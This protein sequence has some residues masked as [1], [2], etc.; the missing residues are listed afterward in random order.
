MSNPSLNFSLKQQQ[1]QK[2]ALTQQMQQSI[3]I[4]Q[5][6]QDELSTYITD[7]ASENPLFEV[8]SSI[9]PVQQGSTTK[10]LNSR[11]YPTEQMSI[12]DQYTSLFE[13][14]IDQVHLNYRD[15]P[16]RKAILFLVEFIDE[17]GYL[18]LSLDDAMS[19][20]SADYLLVLDALTLLQQLDPAGIGA[21]NLQECLMLQTERN[22]EAPEL[23]YVV[24]EEHFQDLADRKWQKISDTYD[25]PVTD[26]Q[27]IMDYVQTL[28]PAPGSH[29]GTID[30][31]YIV[32]EVEV[33]V[34]D[35]QL[36]LN[37]LQS[38]MPKMKFQA[39]Y[40]DKMKATGDPE[41]I[42][43]LNEKKR[44]FDWLSKTVDQRRNTI[45]A[46]TEAIISVQHDFFL[47]E[48][49]PLKSLT[50]KQVGKM[51]GI[52]ES[53]VSRAVNG[54]YLKTDFGVYELRTFFVS[55]I[56]GQSTS[57]PEI[58]KQIIELISAEDKR[59]PISDQKMSDLL[60]KIGISIS[61]RT[62]AKYRENLGIPATSKRKR[63]DK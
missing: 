57:N 63:F 47:K 56:A 21:R 45:V 3:A 10:T 29:F 35:N 5:K 55:A 12:P 48:N 2:L 39:N 20:L 44:E 42:T 46:V 60:Q 40:F 43:Y 25:V 58:K 7:K 13:Y 54:K 36:Q 37:Y 61:R 51:I 16:I 38:G 23:A 26:I 15:T 8:I 31:G 9:A 62:V 6:N 11:G 53:T 41:V 14:L 17:N 33:K 22:P 28:S 34:V 52:H 4:L 59:H 24:L 30:R 49:H 32:P 1:G 19:K 50:L 18:T 27:T